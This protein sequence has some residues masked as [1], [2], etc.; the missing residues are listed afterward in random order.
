MLSKPAGN[1]VKEQCTV[2]VSRQWGDWRRITVP[3]SAL[4][5]LHIAAK[6]GGVNVHLPRPTL[7]AYM[8]CEDIPAGAD[9]GHSCVHGPPPHTIKVLILKSH[10]TPATYRKLYVE[11]E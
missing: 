6:S 8:S 1:L 5:G 2:V 7:A 4:S 9:F 3:I 11:T 10:N